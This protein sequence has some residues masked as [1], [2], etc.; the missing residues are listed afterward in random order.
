MENISRVMARIDVIKSQI[1]VPAGGFQAALDAQ[2]TVIDP[3]METRRPTMGVSTR[4]SGTPLS[5]EVSEYVRTHSLDERN[6]RLDPS[7]LV[8]ISG[9]WGDRDYALIPPAA[10]S[11]ERMRRAAALDGI[12]LRVI[13]AY[14]SWEVQAAAYEDYLAGRKKEHVLPPGT[15]EHGK[16][17]AVDFTNGAIIGRDDPEWHWLSANAREFGWHPISNESWHWEFRGS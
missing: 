11:F 4:V 15:S 12:D 7:E 13:D 1:G 2:M 9:G 6:G 8:G 5:A 10:D 17:M 14:R 3:V 16:G